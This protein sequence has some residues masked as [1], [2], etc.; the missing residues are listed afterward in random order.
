MARV[1]RSE[2]E[3]FLWRKDRKM[4]PKVRELAAR[5]E[6][7]E[8]ED[9]T[10]LPD[11]TLDEAKRRERKERRELLSVGKVRPVYAVVTRTTRH[12]GGPEE[13]G[14]WYDRQNVEAVQRAWD[15]RSL[16]GVV[17]SL[18]QDYPTNLHGRYSVL[19]D[20]GDVVIYLVR[21]AAVIEEL[22]DSNERPRY[23]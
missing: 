20:S 21:D 9:G 12:Y 13:G 2:D 14:W 6:G 15:Y 5:C 3:Q 23:E 18:M 16:L 10:E 1:E 7:L 4:R 22:Q 8:L 19:G 17:R 11:E